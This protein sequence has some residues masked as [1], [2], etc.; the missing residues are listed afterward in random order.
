MNSLNRI[1]ESSAMPDLRCK[2]TGFLWKV[3]EKNAVEFTLF[4]FSRVLSR[5][6]ILRETGALR[7][8]RLVNIN[9]VRKK[10]FHRYI[11]CKHFNGLSFFLFL[12]KRGKGAL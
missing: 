9:T 7:H 10:V 2:L 4:S 3:K 5:S 6:R 1:T 12:R 8:F 11:R